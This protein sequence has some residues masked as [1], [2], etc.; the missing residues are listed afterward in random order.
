MDILKDADTIEYFKA[1]LERQDSLAEAM[2]YTLR[3]APLLPLLKTETKDEKKNAP[4]H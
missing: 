3:N 2:W 1:E 4:D